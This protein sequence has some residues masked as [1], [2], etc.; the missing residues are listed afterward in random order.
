VVVPRELYHI[1]GMSSEDYSLTPTAL[2]VGA[3]D[4]VGSGGGWDTKLIRAVVND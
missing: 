2:G 3:E 4:V 1:G